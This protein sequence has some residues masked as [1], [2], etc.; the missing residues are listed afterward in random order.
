MDRFKL[1]ILYRELQLCSKLSNA[2]FSNRQVVVEAVDRVLQ[3]KVSKA[4]HDPASS[5]GF[6]VPVAFSIGMI[7][8]GVVGGG[9]TSDAC[10]QCPTTTYNR[11]GII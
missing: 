11:D 5:T 4:E 6:D 3:V 9:E 7:G 10:G 1:N 8:Q 2:L